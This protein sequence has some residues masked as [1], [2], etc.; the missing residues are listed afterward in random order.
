MSASVKR[1]QRIRR[2]VVDD[3]A[4]DDALSPSRPAKRARRVSKT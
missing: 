1:S 4:S 3:A 2:D